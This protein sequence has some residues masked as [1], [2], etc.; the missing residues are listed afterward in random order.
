MKDL[1]LAKK[2][3][4][5]Q[6]NNV[7]TILKQAKAAEAKLRERLGRQ[8]CPLIH[9]IEQVLKA[10]RIVKPYYHGGKCNGQAM[11]H[12]DDKF[13]QNHGR[14]YPSCIKTSRK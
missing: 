9:S 3:L 2:Q 8:F 10:N 7:R 12:L 5:D 13:K 14:N 1:K 4:Q 11:N 6:S